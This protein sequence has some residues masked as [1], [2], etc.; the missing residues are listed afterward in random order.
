MEIQKSEY[1]ENK[2]S[3]L[4]EIKSIFHNYLRAII[5]WKHEKK[6]AQAFSL[7]NLTNLC[8]TETDF[9]KSNPKLT[10]KF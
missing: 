6:Q 1:P 5:W 9:C 7:M 4:D 8:F 3:F 10:S 2:S